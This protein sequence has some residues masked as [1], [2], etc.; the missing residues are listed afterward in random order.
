MLTKIDI[1]KIQELIE[2]NIKNLVTKDE[3]SELKKDVNE[4]K[5]MFV[6]LNNFI[7]KD[8]TILY[9][10]IERHS[11]RLHILETRVDEIEK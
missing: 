10:N 9:Y 3:F 4:I 8:T 6:G 11:E 5:D 2:F 7:R 1:N